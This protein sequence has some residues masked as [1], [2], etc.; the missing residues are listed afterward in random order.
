MLPRD[1]AWSLLLPYLS[2]LPPTRLP[3]REARGRVLA[4]GVTATVD[5]PSADVSAMDGYAFAGDH[6]AGARLKV[7]GRIAA[8]ERPGR[9]LPE[10]AALKIMTGAPVPVGADR[11]IPFELTDRGAETVEITRPVDA[12]ANIRRCGEVMETGAPLLAP[13]AVLTAEALALLATHGVG[14][15]AVH[16][17]PRVAVLTTGDEVLPPEATPE[18]GQLR[19]SHTDFL[20]AGCAALGVEARALGIAPDEPAELARRLAAGLDDSDV[21]LVGGGVSAGELDYV[22]GTLADLGCRAL[23]TSVAIQPGK[24]LT[25]AVRPAEEDAQGRQRLVFGL[26]GNPG[27]VMVTF[28][29]FVRPALRRL[30]GHAAAAPHERL[31]TGVLA[32]SSSRAKKRDLY[33]P[34]RAEVRDGVLAVEPLAPRGSHDLLAHARSNALLYLPAESGEGR[35][36]EACQVLPLD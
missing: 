15:L 1:E 4:E 3:R 8:G 19:D 13:G 33:L 6:A 29:L 16:P 11:V 12:G 25:V 7:A 21:L 2:P 22:E 28:H 18:P 24:P 9:E 31:Q 32:G 34:A 27:S 35:V 17:A 20:T 30:M 5:V 26:P 10:G 23:F 14:E 36:G